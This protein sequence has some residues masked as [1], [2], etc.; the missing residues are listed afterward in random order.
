[1]HIP[2]RHQGAYKALYTDAERQR[3]DASPWTIVQAILA[4][5]QF[6][7]F[8]AS[9]GFVLHTL[10]TGDGAHLAHASIV[11]KTLILYA[12]MVTGSLWE[13]D[14]FGRY[15]FAPAFFWE[16]AVSFVVIALHTAYIAYL[17]TGSLTDTPLLIL[18]LTAYAAYLFNAVQF[19]LKLRAA[20][21]QY[22]GVVQ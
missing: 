6:I 10:V 22:A 20:R 2:R 7:V 13:K 15:L 16:D 1:M 17:L 18:A 14:V 12:I 19:L 9:L 8:L 4:P 3:R 5:L 21:L 11:V